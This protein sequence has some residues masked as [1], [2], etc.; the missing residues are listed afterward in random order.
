MA[1]SGAKLG[2]L[3]CMGAALGYARL[4]AVRRAR[5]ER[6]AA[7]TARGPAED[8]SLSSWEVQGRPGE[9]KNRER[10]TS[11]E[12]LRLER[13]SV[14]VQVP[15]TSANLG[16]GFDCIGMAVDMWNEL[17]VERA[18]KFCITV[19]GEGADD[20][21]LDSSNLVC[22]GLEAAFKAAGKPVPPL[23]YHLKQRIPH[24]R[25]L[26]SSSAAIV[27]GILAGL[28]IAGHKLDVHGRE[29]MLQLATEI[30][31]HP[32]NVAPCMY[33]GCQIGV[34][35]ETQKR[36][37][38]ERVS[39]PHGLVFVMFIPAFVGKT[40][41]LRKVVPRTVSI[42]DAVFNMGRIAWLVLALTT[43]KIENL[44][45]AVEDRLHQPQ[46]GAAVYRHL[47]PLMEAAYRGGAAAAYLSGAGPVVMALTTGG[48][49]DF[50]TQN[51]AQRTDQRVA[52]EMQETADRLKVP[53]KVYVTHPTQV[54]GVVV[55]A[56]PPFSTSNLV[57]NGET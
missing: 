33:G 8:T 4:A 47:F 9:G 2:A 15:G 23:H 17:T 6:Q 57:F 29:E 25:G 28:V 11:C 43:G 1:S 18:D 5:A 55:K 3:L 10:L 37:S 12:I 39:L 45:L 20:I 51:L 42:H 32:D 7:D 31:G 35:D 44:R 50:F 24:G 54:G 36:W 13:R 53:G 34:Y 22:V 27:S 19:E 46:R 40:S 16:C 49:G 26:G 38:T 30:E 52:R 14:T 41:E 56:D 21:P 48:S